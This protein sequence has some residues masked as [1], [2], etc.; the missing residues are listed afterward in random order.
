M[1]NLLFRNMTSGDRHRKVLSSS[2]I[3]DKDGVRTVVH[4][5]FVYLV[6]EM[7]KKPDEVEQPCLA[8]IKERNSREKFERFYCRMKGCMVVLNNGRLFKINFMHS[9]RICLA[10]IPDGMTRYTAEA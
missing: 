10:S 3:V 9:L 6:R 1:R 4:R 5:H 7:D 8:V 2:E